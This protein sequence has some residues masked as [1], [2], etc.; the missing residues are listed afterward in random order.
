MG[1]S[2]QPGI[3]RRKRI[4]EIL[5]SDASVDTAQLSNELG[6]S[7]MTIR[8]D[9]KALESQNMVLRSYGGATLTHR[10]HLEFQFDQSRQGALAA[11]QEIGRYAARLID[12]GETIFVDT[13]TTTL[14]FAR[15][16]ARRDINVTVATSSLAVG[17]ELWG[18][19]HI[20]VLMLGGQLR[21][22]SPD[23]TGPLCEHS[24][25]MLN[26]SKAFL[27]CDALQ[28]DR[29]CFATDTEGARVSSTMLRYASWSCVL[30][31]GS[32]IGKHATVRYAGLADIDLLITDDTA[33]QDELDKIRQDGGCK[34]ELVTVDHP[35][36]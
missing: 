4:L 35:P 5:R 8:R 24:L 11:K 14:E 33:P 12:P 34:L 15:E 7:E 25:D 22:N 6:V 10:L 36:A 16:L 9:L 26:A 20:R 17:S 3:E 21:A 23:L 32:K 18:H 2:S 1:R 31:D 28:A 29:G 30:A 19:G 27:G 13:G